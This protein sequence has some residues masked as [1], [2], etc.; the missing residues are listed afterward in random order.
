[1]KKLFL[2]IS[3][4]IAVQGGKFLDSELL[5]SNAYP[6]LPL[7]KLDDYVNS[8]SAMC[9]D[10]SPAAYYLR[11]VEG[12]SGWILY[13]EGGGWCYNIEDCLQRSK[14]DLG[15]SRNYASSIEDD[16]GGLLSR[17]PST[18]IFHDFNL[19]YMK[20]C[21]GNSFSGNL[22]SPLVVNGTS[23][24]FRGNSVREAVLDHLLKTTNIANATKIV[25][26]GCSAGGLAA[27]LH[28]DSHAEWINKNLPSVVSFVNIPISGFFI[29]E[30]NALNQRVYSEQIKTIF[31][32]SNATA[33]LNR[34]CVEFLPK[35]D[36]WKCNFAEFSFS[37]SK[38]RTFV[39]M[40]QVDA[41]ATA[42]IFAS[43]P[44][45]P[46]SNQN[47]NCSAVPGFQTCGWNLK[48]CPSGEGFAGVVDFQQKFRDRIQSNAGVTR[49]GNGGYFSSCFTHCEGQ[50]QN[51]WTKWRINGVAMNEAV[52]NWYK[53]S[54][55]DSAK[56]HT[57]TDCVISENMPHLCNDS[58]NNYVMFE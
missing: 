36:A 45:S 46:G 11:T 29:N 43:E 47:G 13:F 53:S 18:N 8:S 2:I 57:Y 16:F 7:I 12:S 5:N 27:F 1:M 51:A 19:V 40:S 21:D 32:L 42:C 35:D 23:L 34:N 15:S 4:V 52:A 38:V 28:A 49:D 37:F 54:V 22:D 9:L 56:I 3:L 41:W 26:T 55:G 20:Y 31:T 58:C 50:N 33:G 17:D 39:L 24:Y 30:A 14:S 6:S 44:I 25:Q 48:T 10:G